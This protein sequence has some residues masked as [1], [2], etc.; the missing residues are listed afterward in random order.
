MKIIADL[1]EAH[2]FRI[3]EEGLEF[4]MLKRSMGRKYPGLWQMV[5]GHL[6]KNETAVETVLR[7]VK[8]ETGL[9]PDR[10]WVAPNVNSLYNPEEDFVSVIPVFAAQVEYNAKVKISE[11]HTEYKWVSAAEAKN[12]LAWEGQRKSVELI[13]EYFLRGMEFLQFTEIKLAPYLKNI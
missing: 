1:I 3:G 2:V 6:D 4:L 5:S 11:E 12:M 13:K 7:E 9:I 8:E 10:L